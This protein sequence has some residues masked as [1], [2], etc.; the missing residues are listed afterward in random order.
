[1]LQEAEADYVYV[2]NA[3]HVH[4]EYALKA[5]QSG[6]NVLVEKPIT[7]TRVEME[8]LIDCA[9]QHCVYCLPAFSLL[10]NPLYRQLQQVVQELG[11]PRMVM[12]H[13]A[14]RSSRY[15]RE[16]IKKG[17]QNWGNN[18]YQALVKIKPNS[19]IANVEKDIFEKVLIKKRY[20][21]EQL[22]K[23]NV[24]L[25]EMLTKYGPNEFY[26]TRLDKARLE[27]K[28]GFKGKADYKTIKILF[29]LSVLILILSAINFIN[30]KTAQGSQRAK[31]VGVKKA[32][33]STKT[34]LIF[35]FL[36]EAM[37]ICVFAYFLSLVLVELL[38]P[39]YNKFLDKEMA[40]NDWTIYAY[41]AIMTFL[42]VLFSG[43][44]PAIYLSN[45]KP[46]NTLK[47]NFSRSSHGVWLRNG[48]LT[49]QLI[50]SSFFI[51]GG[52]I[53]HQ[54]VKY[55]MNKDLGFNGNQVITIYYSTNDLSYKKYILY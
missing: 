46:I 2:A 32:I 15:D 12:G 53:I 9:I 3:N 7:V 50:I 36:V 13:Y 54:Q 4:H 35:Q 21:K 43:L 16:N 42:V 25:E 8:E 39:S 6:H 11:T 27:A 37:L 18:S 38:L 41:S 49:L 55:M 28:S 1:M 29:G 40:M 51:I 14:Q 52:I 31:E 22:Q 24:T 47:G 44:I 48:I 5:M 30:L 19:N 23:E 33:G 45:F 20:P 17:Y 10:Y 26:L 34:Q